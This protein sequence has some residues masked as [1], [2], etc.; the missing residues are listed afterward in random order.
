MFRGVP[1]FLVLVHAVYYSLIVTKAFIRSNLHSFFFLLGLFEYN[2]S[3]EGLS[4]WPSG[5]IWINTS[6]LGIYLLHN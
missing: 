4:V 3:V 2:P 1:V 5:C 6:V